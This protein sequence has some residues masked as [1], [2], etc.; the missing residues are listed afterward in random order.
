MEPAA[1]Q[2]HRV[3]I[4]ALEIEAA[5]SGQHHVV[6]DVTGPGS[7]PMPDDLFG[8]T[9]DVHIGRVDEVAASFDEG[10]EDGE[11]VGLWRLR[12]KIH[13]S[14]GDLSYSDTGIA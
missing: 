8:H 10:V 9:V 7:K 4:L 3:H 1:R 2:S 6:R 11:S 14:K 13:R 12:A 5:L